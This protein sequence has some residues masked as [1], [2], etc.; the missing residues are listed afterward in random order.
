MKKIISRSIYFFSAITLI[1]I[2]IIV[3][4]FLV[5]D[6]LGARFKNFDHVLLASDIIF[7]LALIHGLVGLI[8]YFIKKN[9]KSKLNDATIIL[10]AFL[11]LPISI[12]I[13]FTPLPQ[14]LYP[15]EIGENMFSTIFSFIT[16]IGTYAALFW[17]ILI[18]KTFVKQIIIMLTRKSEN[19]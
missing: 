2:G 1:S 6:D 14:T 16:I 11:I 13:A 7:L 18:F 3:K 9:K 19:K 10:S 5:D 4:L 12:I 15:G 17:V 8:F